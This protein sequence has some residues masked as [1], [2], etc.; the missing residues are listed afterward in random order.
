MQKPFA[1]IPIEGL[2]IITDVDDVTRLF[3]K[4]DEEKAWPALQFAGHN[5]SFL[6]GHPE[7]LAPDMMVTPLDIRAI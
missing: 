5:R 6:C 1:E 4:R 7:I 2:F 3:L